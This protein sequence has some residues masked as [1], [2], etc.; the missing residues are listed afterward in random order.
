MHRYPGGT[1]IY[2]YVSIWISFLDGLFRQL[3]CDLLWVF[4]W[5]TKGMSAL[6]S[7]LVS[8]AGVVKELIN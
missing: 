1:R 7:R 4:C 3:H 2:G 5:I 8:T 6:K